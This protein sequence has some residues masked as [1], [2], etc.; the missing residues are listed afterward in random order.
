MLAAREQ[1]PNWDRLYETAAGQEGLFTTQQAAQ[2]GYSPQLLVHHVRTGKVLRVQRGI[3]RLV[4]FP[5]G[6]HEELVASW[7]WSERAGVVSHQ[8][9]LALHGLS[10]VLPAQ[11][12]LTLPAAWRRRRFRVPA[13]VVLHHAD[14]AAADRS[15]F[16]SVPITSPRRTLSDCARAPLSPELLSQAAHQALRRGLVGRD[17]LGDVDVALKPFGGLAP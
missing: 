17:E 1:V 11:V 6:E 15:W 2:A 9:A 3:Y 10:D 5:A 12:H 16:G 13:D 14:V 7:L 8:S 4:H